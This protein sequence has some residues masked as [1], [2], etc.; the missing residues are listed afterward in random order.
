LQDLWVFDGLYWTWISG[1]NQIN[2]KGIYGD[3][4]VPFPSN[5][6]GG[7]EGSLC[8][9]DNEGSFWMFGGKGYGTIF[10]INY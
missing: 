7:R 2:Q 9:V 1:S 10:I 5:I 8:W 3:K 4:K 6:P